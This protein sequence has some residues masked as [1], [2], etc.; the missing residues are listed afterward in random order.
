MPRPP[1][2]EVPGGVY[3]VTARG[4]RGQ[5]IFWDAQD[6]GTY[7]H[8]LARAAARWEVRILAYAL[9]PNH[10]HLLVRTGR[11]PLGNVMHAVQ[12]TFARNWNRRRGLKG[13]VFEARYFARLCLA[14]R[15]LWA[16]V[17]YVHDNPV[18][19]GLVAHPGLYQW[20]SYP[21]YETRRWRL[22][23]P[24]EAAAILGSVRPEDLTWV[25]AIGAGDSSGTD[26]RNRR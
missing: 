4:N 19:A 24:S 6:Y 1:R 16:L 13:H 18:R 7:L 21:E 2:V 14:E 23:D 8:L 20:S 26:G 25:S 17:R 11:M 9:M 12:G 5:K 22:V 3:N 10:L 15:Y